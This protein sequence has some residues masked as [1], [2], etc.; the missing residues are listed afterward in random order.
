MITEEQNIFYRDNGYLIVKKVLSEESCDNYLSQIKKHANNDFA[1]IMNP[2][3]FDFLVAQSFENIIGGL[4]L[5][6]RVDHI[7]EC[8][9]TSQMTFEIM[10]IR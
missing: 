5:S 2:D 1:A 3:R 6:D 8:R 10:A 4:S 7:E 9:K